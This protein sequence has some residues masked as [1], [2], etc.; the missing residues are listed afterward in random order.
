MSFAKLFEHLSSHKSHRQDS[1]QIMS[2][3]T[4][5]RCFCSRGFFVVE[6]EMS[7]NCSKS[8]FSVLWKTNNGICMKR[9]SVYAIGCSASLS[10]IV[11]R[12]RGRSS[13]RR[14]V[15]LFWIWA[16]SWAIPRGNGFT[17][18]A[19]WFKMLGTSCVHLQLVRRNLQRQRNKWQRLRIIKLLSVCSIKGKVD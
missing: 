11:S 5:K 6:V 12:L 4:S 2:S 14:K 7:Y 8:V 1:W 3:N 19:K 13:S 18:H 15:F 17:E 10:W 16:Q 9:W